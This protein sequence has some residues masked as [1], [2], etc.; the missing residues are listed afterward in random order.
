M[1]QVLTVSTTS[2]A[3]SPLCL[4]GSRERGEGGKEG[5]EGG[6]E[7]VYIGAATLCNGS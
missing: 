3:G 2:R 1:G 5:R 7:C 4:C 6:E